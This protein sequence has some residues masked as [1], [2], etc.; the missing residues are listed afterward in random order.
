MKG[1]RE[2][3]QKRE[4]ERERDKEKETEIDLQSIDPQMPTTATVG[5][6][7]ARSLEHHLG[8]P[9]G[10]Q[11][12]KYMSHLL[13]PSMMSISRKLALKFRWAQSEAV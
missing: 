10:W 3:E 4:R 1:G 7:K 11:G 6:A 13:L 12:L 5:K 9:Y 8:L 2:R